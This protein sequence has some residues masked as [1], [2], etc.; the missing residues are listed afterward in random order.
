VKAEYLLIGILRKR[1]QMPSSGHKKLLFK[2]NGTFTLVQ[3]TDNPKYEN[4]SCH[5]SVAGTDFTS[6]PN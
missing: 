1:V 4:F 2:T 3:K 6:V 5:L